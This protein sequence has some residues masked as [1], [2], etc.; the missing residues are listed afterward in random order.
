MKKVAHNCLLLLHLQLPSLPSQLWLPQ[1][2]SISFRHLGMEV[3]SSKMCFGVSSNLTFHKNYHQ[4]CRH[5][6]QCYGGQIKTSNTGSIL[7]L[8][9]NLHHYQTSNMGGF[10]SGMFWKNHRALVAMTFDV[11]GNWSSSVKASLQVLNSPSSLSAS[12]GF[13]I[14]LDWSRTSQP[15]K[16]RIMNHKP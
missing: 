6:L 11:V 9:C 7:Y 3:K 5:F 2:F 12:S 14:Q 15:L 1:L 8:W 4:K 10:V 16:T 13:E